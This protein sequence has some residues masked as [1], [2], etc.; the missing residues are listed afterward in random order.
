[1]GYSFTKEKLNK[2][3][4]N[5]LAIGKIPFTMFFLT[6]VWYDRKV[7][8]YFWASLYIVS[9]ILICNLKNNNNILM[10]ILNNAMEDINVSIYYFIQ[11]M[12]N[13]NKL[14]KKKIGGWSKQAIDDQWRILLL[15]FTPSAGVSRCFRGTEHCSPNVRFKR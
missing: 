11:L 13:N 4:I 15:Q 8:K 10:I 7:Y 5:V 1:L 9:S 6:W 3:K 12:N 14:K 2:G